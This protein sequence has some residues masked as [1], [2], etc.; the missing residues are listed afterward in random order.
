MADDNRDAADSLAMLLRLAGHEVRTAHDGLAAVAVAAETR[1]DVAV[2]DIGMPGLTGYDAARRI[3]AEPWGR[4]VLLVALTGWGQ[5]G[6]R[7]R[8]AE[9]GF[10]HHLTKPVDPEA[11]T[12]LLAGAPHGDDDR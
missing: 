12:R 6:D 9:A 7:Q 2:L 8:A 5:D 3:R 10:D 11:L 1:P 4:G